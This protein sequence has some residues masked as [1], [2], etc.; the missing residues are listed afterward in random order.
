[1]L[2]AAPD[3]A[4]AGRDLG[5]RP[6]SNPPHSKGK[7]MSRRRTLVTLTS[8]AVAAL[9]T[10]SLAACGDDDDD[11]A[12]AG[13][14]D[15]AAATTGGPAATVGV[16]PTNLG[17]ILVDSQGRTLYLFQADSG[18]TSACTG[19]CATFWPPLVADGAAT[20]AGGADAALLGTSARTDG[21]TQVTYNGHPVYTYTG[22]QKAGD[23]TGEGLNAF[24]GNW[25]VLSSA[26]DQVTGAPAAP[27]GNS[28][29]GG[30]SGY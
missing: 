27:A 4:V 22:D 28:T 9:V 25:Y 8:V 30:V 24:G 11:S 15:T 6:G 1:V 16:A 17:D 23:T 14:P 12:S 7:P 29:S 26:G 13:A 2:A 20:V 3:A 10:L 21:K 19:A 5:H 18:T